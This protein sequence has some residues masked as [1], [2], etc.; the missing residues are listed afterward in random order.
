MHIASLPK[1]LHVQH[2]TPVLHPDKVMD[3][4]R[5]EATPKGTILPVLFTTV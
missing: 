1:Y 2:H 5:V 3:D 4:M